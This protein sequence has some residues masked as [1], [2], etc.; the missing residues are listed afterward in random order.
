MMIR[1]YCK[2]KKLRLERDMTQSDLAKMIG[3]SR[4]SIISLESGRY[5]P[6][7]PLALQLAKIFDTTV[8]DIF[9]LIEEDTSLTLIDIDETTCLIPF[10]E[11]TV[12]K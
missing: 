8:E 3:I 4:Q 5:N 10:E 12:L 9:D 7:L 11:G 1:I 2:I 6:S